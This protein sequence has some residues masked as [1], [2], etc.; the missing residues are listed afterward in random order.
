M[1]VQ[2]M[3]WALEQRLVTSATQRHVLLCLANY[4][5][6]DGRAAFPSAGSLA[7]DTGLS[8]RT[9]RTALE[10]L[11][12]LGV[13]TLGNQA[14]AAAYID[15]HDR[16]PVVYDLAMPRG[17]TAAPRTTKRGESPA[18][19]ESERGAAH[20]K[21]G[22]SSRPNGVQELHPIRP[23]TINDPK[24]QGASAPR[25]AKFDPRT[26]RPAEVSEA[27]WADWCQHRKEIRKPL[28]ATSCQHQAK[29]LAGHPAADAV[30]THSI[31]NGYTGLFPQKV[32]HAASQNTGSQRA[33]SAVDDVRAAI[34]ARETA[35]DAARHAVAED[36]RDVRP[37]LDGEFRR[38]G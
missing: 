15:R 18:P 34:A 32:T 11:R 19:R 35:T 13:I 29:Q 9:V 8:L 31:A 21:T 10:Q 33:G 25:A 23:L 7:D 14:I 30:I 37:A 2:A 4:A 5:D 16:R 3:T 6:K 20:D 22:C 12:E 1:S 36:D 38:V 17:A 28:T 24:E 27:V 26:A